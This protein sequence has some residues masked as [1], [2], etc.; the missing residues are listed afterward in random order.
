MYA[1]QPTKADRNEAYATPSP[2]PCAL[3]FGTRLTQARAAQLRAQML[4]DMRERSVVCHD[5]L[6]GWRFPDVPVPQVSL[7]V[8]YGLR[9]RRRFFLAGLWTLSFYGPILLRHPN[10]DPQGCW[11]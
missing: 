4:L 1:Y 10:S 9:R 3:L 2:P 6:P 5:K 8:F 7:G 11:I